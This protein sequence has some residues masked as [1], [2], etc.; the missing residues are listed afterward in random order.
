MTPSVENFIQHN[1]ALFIV[2]SLPKFNGMEW[3]DEFD[4]NVYDFGARNYD[5]AIVRTFIPDP[6][7]EAFTHLYPYSLL[8][9]NPLSHM[10][11]LGAGPSTRAEAIEKKLYLYDRKIKI[12]WIYRQT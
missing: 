11:P 12:L 4:V 3:Q 9:N 2:G 1:N 5:P 7:A 10:N 6:L 8:N